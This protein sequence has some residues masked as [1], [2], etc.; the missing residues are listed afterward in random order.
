VKP[1]WTVTLIPL[2]IIAS[3]AKIDDLPKM[4]VEAWMNLSSHG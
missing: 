1:A 2:R 3:G 4:N